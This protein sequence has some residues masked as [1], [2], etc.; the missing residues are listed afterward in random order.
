MTG[1]ATLWTGATLTSLAMNAALL[2]VIWIT[3]RPNPVSDQEPDRPDISISAY[4]I[5]ER[6]S[7]PRDAGGD[8]AK[9]VD[10]HGSRSTA[11][12]AVAQSRATAVEP[13][14]PEISAATIPDA[15]MSASVP[16]PNPITAI[17]DMSTTLPKAVIPDRIAAAITVPAQTADPA[18]PDTLRMQAHS[19]NR[20][21][22]ALSA[23]DTS[24]RVAMSPTRAVVQRN[25]A[26]EI[27]AARIINAALPSPST[28][29]VADLAPTTA[30][31]ALPAQLIPETA[32]PADPSA[33][34]ELISPP[35]A[36]ADVPSRPTAIATLP[37]Q[38]AAIADVPSQ[39]TASTDLPSIM[40]TSA[41][42]VA[43]APGDQDLRVDPVSLAAIQSFMQPKSG[44]A[45]TARDE[46]GLLLASI[47]CSRLQAEFL[48]E[49]GVMELR[50]H[51]PDNALRA[52]VLDALR[53]NLGT[54]I[55][56]TDNLRIL[57]PPQC[58]A[59]AGI[60]SVGLPQSNDQ[61]SDPR[62]VGDGT[63]ARS[64]DYTTGQRMIFDIVAPDYDAFIYVD[65]FD[66]DGQVIHLVPNDRVRLEQ[67]PA[68]EISRVGAER[69]DGQFLEVTVG[70]P[71]GQEIAVAFAAS[72]E[73]YSG[74]RPIEE[75]AAPY[76]EF[77]QQKVAEARAEDPDFR[78]E[79]VYFFVETTE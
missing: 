73:L 20:Q 18:K 62:L 75:P 5:P 11:N 26:I 33:P 36:V 37:S 9:P 65:Y 57:P 74:S 40:N 51:L 38:P 47:P 42:S 56:V 54:T 63:Q 58:Q 25:A 45:T 4:A 79:W 16:D 24:N 61:Q 44:T 35:A 78:G 3:L 6:R 67:L 28:S 41:I 72:Q 53:Q 31:A 22:T 14:T 60:S 59:L 49:S 52:P 32:A 30:T 46:I 17:A 70:P 43:F 13:E 29:P 50:G 7:E 68:K 12:A 8:T 15:P 77:L 48:P 69:A 66:A 64:Y 21:A 76:L 55:P 34:A 23:A 39:P 27:S 2:A 10:A 71:Y 1:R 19:A